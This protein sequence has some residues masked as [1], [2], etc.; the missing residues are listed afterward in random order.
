M[1]KIAF[2]GLGQMGAPMAARLLQAGHVLRV[3]DRTPM[4][5]APLVEHGAVAASSPA[6]AAAG[7][8]FAITMLATPDALEQ[9][10]LGDEGVARVLHP[11]QVHIDM[12]TVGPE[13]VR[14]I[15]SRLPAGVPLVDAPVRGSVPQAAEGRLEI[16]AGASDTD[17]DRVRPILESLGTVRHIGGPGSGA[18]MKLVANLVLG[19]AIAALGEA[20]AIG[21]SLALGRGA[22]LD[23]LADSPI[24]PAVRAKRSNV[25]S[26]RYPPSFKLRHAAKD[27][28]LVTDAA[29]ATGRDLKVARAA[30]AWLDEAVL[31]GAGDLDY[32]AV[33]ATILGED[34]SG[35]GGPAVFDEQPNTPGPAH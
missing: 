30:R 19:A 34:A 7:V 17:F 21:E 3:W 24:G 13:A 4:R 8:D 25:E 32:S 31:H 6:E 12:S 22:V 18:A 15:A 2:L 9:V 26:G 11:A 20:L 29:A 10:M 5:A 35:P 14:W 1:S 27:L 33:V 23:M 28:K 16:F